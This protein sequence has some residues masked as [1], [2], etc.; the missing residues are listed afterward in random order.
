MKKILAFLAAAVCTLGV[1]AADTA[2][3][4]VATFNKMKMSDDGGKTWSEPLD[5]AGTFELGVPLASLTVAGDKQTYDVHET[6]KNADG[7][8][9]YRCTTKEN[10]TVTIAYNA[11]ART[12]EATTSIGTTL[13]MVTGERAK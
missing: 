2:P 11:K 13:F 4:V 1:W 6:T 12:I 10:E 9:T 8:W 5:V 7:V 3:Q